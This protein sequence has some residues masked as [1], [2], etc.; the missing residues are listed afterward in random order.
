MWTTDFRDDKDLTPD[1]RTYVAQLVAAR[2]G[3]G[4]ADAEKRVNQ[5]IA[6]AKATAREDAAWR[7]ASVVLAHRGA[8]VR[9]FRSKLGCC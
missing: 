9:R 3:L 5:V 6:E 2:T 7:R 1:D 8:P 4:Q